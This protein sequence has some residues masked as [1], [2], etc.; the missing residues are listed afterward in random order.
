M[1]GVAPLAAVV[2][3]LVLFV[4]PA[5]AATT[6]VQDQRANSLALSYTTDTFAPSNAFGTA[7]VGS[8][9]Q[10]Q[11][12][13][14]ISNGVAD[15]S[16]SWMFEFEG[17][18]DLSGT[19]DAS[20]DLGMLTPA[21]VAGNGYDGTSDLD[22]WYTPDASQFNPDGSAKAH[23]SASFTNGKLSAG[24]GDLV[25]PINFAGATVPLTLSAVQIQAAT[26][27]SSTPLS[28]SGSPPG[29][30]ASEHV[31]PNLTS[32]GSLSA[33]KLRGNISAGSLAAVNVPSAL[34]GPACNNYY[35][36]ASTLL[37]LFVSGCKALGITNEINGT[38]PDTVSATGSGTYAFSVGQGHAVTGCT[39]N[40]VADTLADCLAGAAYSSYFTFTTDRVIDTAKQ[41]D[42]KVL[43]V[44]LSGPGV[45]SVSGT[46]ID[47]G[48]DCSEA[49][50]AGTE[51]QLTA[52]PGQDSVSFG[53]V[54]CDN[55]STTTCTMTMGKDKSVAAVFAIKPRVFCHVPDV[56][57]KTLGKAKKALTHAHC[58][59]GKVTRAYSSTVK[60]GRVISQKPTSGTLDEG[61]KVNLDV[62]KGK[63]P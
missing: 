30:L 7:I 35:T 28:S 14:A 62:S 39:H 47:C 42:G 4:G 19:N 63:K 1:R 45:G 36:G 52:T 13:T 57:G 56:K 38:Q 33:G 15:G 10:S 6:F 17:L 2:A 34:T 49:Y 9:A 61:S 3:V 51:V 55:A 11:I 58:A 29:H 54:G 27:A 32:F 18:A 53:W 16:I 31:D 22:W 43:T 37:D 8:L 24:P 46:G 25:L 60:T 41:A 26:G 12:A 40:D 21:P 20:F 23:L 59:V 5:Q 50:D 44:I 48:T